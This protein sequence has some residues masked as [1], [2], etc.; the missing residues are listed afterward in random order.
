MQL[1]DD[2]LAIDE[3]RRRQARRSDR[4]GRALIRVQQD[5][6]RCKLLALK[7]RT[8]PLRI[9]A[10]IDEQ[11]RHGRARRFFDQHRHF[12][13]AWRAP[14]RP[15]IDDERLSP[16]F[17]ERPGLARQRMENESLR[18]GLVRRGEEQ[19]CGCQGSRGAARECDAHGQ[20]RGR[21]SQGQTERYGGSRQ[22][23]ERREAA[24]PDIEN[25]QRLDREGG[26]VLACETEARRQQ[27]YEQCPPCGFLAVLSVA[28]ADPVRRHQED[29]DPEHREKPLQRQRERPKAYHR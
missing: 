25:G 2:S 7:P 17:V 4:G 18:Q 15:E 16:S 9:L 8:H 19:R 11:D 29:N 21:P 10:L 20:Q 12:S 1:A 24:L 23:H 5:I 13:A 22:T 6:G 3:Q 27:A 28:A 26:P 14:T